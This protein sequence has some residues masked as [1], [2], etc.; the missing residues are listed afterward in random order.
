VSASRPDLSVVVV[1]HNGREMALRTLRSGRAA[2]GSIRAEWIV[3]D[4]DS[5]DGTPGAIEAEFAEVEV[6][7][8]ANR[9]FA[10]GNNAGI[11]RAR[12]RYVLL[13][14]PD[15]EVREGTFADLIK[16]LDERPD[17]GIASVV[18]RGAGGE[19]QFSMRR[20]PSP[21]R[22]L[23]ESLG[24]ARWPL[25]RSL[26]ELDVRAGHY[27]GEAS[28]DWIVG[29]FLCARA[30]A[31]AAIGPMDDRFFLYSEEIDWCLRARKAGWDVRHIPAMTVTHHAGRRDGGD[32]MAQLA[33]SRMLFARKH[34]G[35][36]GAEGIRWALAAGYLV[37]IAARLPL[38]LSRPKAR[39][40][41]AANRGALSVLFG[42]S[43]PPLSAAPIVAEASPPAPR[44]QEA[45]TR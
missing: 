3:A 44:R 19:L 1:T 34:H 37:R 17:V 21:A 26:Q 4:S 20:F 10:A 15:V 23:G 24:A 38:A 36:L 18:Q 41:I 5:S 28:P 8:V 45:M 22:D 14:N 42:L 33:H 6:L 7:R 16:A 25:L 31:I 35:R 39:R 12:G 29:A 13:L 9:G 30:E 43:G 32:L 2:L 11:A 27:L 40:E